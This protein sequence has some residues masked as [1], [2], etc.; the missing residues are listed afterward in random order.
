MGKSKRRDKSPRQQKWERA[1]DKYDEEAKDEMFR[2]DTQ[3]KEPFHLAEDRIQYVVSPGIAD[4][5]S[6]SILFS[7]EADKKDYNYIGFDVEG[8]SQPGRYS[9]APETLQ[10]YT[11]ADG[12]KRATI[13]QINKIAKNRRLPRD[14]EKLLSY[15]SN[16]FIGK[17]VEK[18]VQDFFRDF[19]ITSNRRDGFLFID[20]LT[21]I[22]TC[23]VYQ[24][25]HPEDAQQYAANGSFFVSPDVPDDAYPKIYYE[26]G[27]RMVVNYFLDC[28]IDKRTCHVHGPLADWSAPKGLSKS[29]LQY[30]ADDVASVYDVL[31]AAAKLLDA[32]RADFIQ[33]SNRDDDFFFLKASF[34]DRFNH[35]DSSSISD[36]ER[37]LKEKIR[38]HHGKKM[39]E[40]TRRARACNEYKS[41]RCVRWREE[42]E[43]PSLLLENP[44][45]TCSDREDTNVASQYCRRR[46]LSTGGPITFGE[47]CHR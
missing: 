25:L 5:V 27:I 19:G 40:D 1:R 46:S 20:V 37:L 39:S 16:V 44:F 22:R 21:L 30:A 35:L 31:S 11:V 32:S 14:L 17:G 42:N 13:F 38:L 2:R 8:T 34:L 10:L 9:K 33:V 41:E 4:R 15:G 7:I 3:R 28:P 29:M 45:P 24:R 23:D 36:A 47:S 43:M 12:M 18:E 6:A 26:A